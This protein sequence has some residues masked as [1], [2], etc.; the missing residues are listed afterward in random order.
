MC[1]KMKLTTEML[2]ESELKK[3]TNELK[4]QFKN[5]D[6]KYLKKIIKFE[7]IVGFKNLDYVYETVVC[8]VLK[9]EEDIYFLKNVITDE[10]DC[11]G[12][13]NLKF[14]ES[15]NSIFILN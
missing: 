14:L 5:Y 8:E 6:K 13:Y 12:L 4:R 10:A 1:G 3:M 15:K 7:K 9:R 11:L 2:L